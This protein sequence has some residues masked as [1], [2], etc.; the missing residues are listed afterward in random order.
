VTNEVGNVKMMSSLHY[1]LPDSHEAEPLGSEFKA[2]NFGSVSLSYRLADFL[3]RLL[4]DN[5]TF[6]SLGTGKH[7]FKSCVTTYRLQSLA[8]SRIKLSEE[9]EEEEEESFYS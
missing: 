5:K 8:A 7:S 3:S 6:N 4:K 9:K 2:Q 1:N